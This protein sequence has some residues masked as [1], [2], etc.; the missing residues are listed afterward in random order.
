MMRL[1]ILSVCLFCA[2]SAWSAVTV[3]DALPNPH[4]PGTR[5]VAAPVIDGVPDDPCWL[6]APVIG[7]FTHDTHPASVSTDVRVLYDDRAMYFAFTCHDPEPGTIRSQ[8][9]K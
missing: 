7:G 8:Q 3:D 1:S 5:A 6:N 4:V 9:R 2:P